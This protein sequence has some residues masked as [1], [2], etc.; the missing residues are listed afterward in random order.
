MKLLKSPLETIL[1]LSQSLLDSIVLLPELPPKAASEAGI[2]LAGAVIDLV[3]LE[4]GV[5]LTGVVIDLAAL[6]PGVVLIGVVINLVALEPEVILV[7]VVAELVTFAAVLRASSTIVAISM[8]TNIFFISKPLFS[9][10]LYESYL[11]PLSI[12]LICL[13]AS[14]TQF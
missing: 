14:N 2:V 8:A 1:G 6:E 11:L 10:N 9:C 3:A 13:G 7:V 5:M 4:L 12:I